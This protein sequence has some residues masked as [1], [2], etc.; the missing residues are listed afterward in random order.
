LREASEEELLEL[1]DQYEIDGPG[2][3]K[4]AQ[5]LRGEHAAEEQQSFA[6]LAEE[7]RKADTAVQ[8]KF[9]KLAKED[10]QRASRDAK[11]HDK[12]IATWEAQ[13]AAA[14]RARARAETAA[15]QARRARQQV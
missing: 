3:L 13:K 11:Q 8:N 10:K 6:E 9:Q 15:E 4:I 12:D 1:F 2:R 14:A 5:E 7:W